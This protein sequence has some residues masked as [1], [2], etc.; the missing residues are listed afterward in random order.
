[1]LLQGAVA[2][3]DHEPEGLPAC[4]DGPVGVFRHPEYPGP[5]GQHPSQPG[6]VVEH[7]G[8]SLGLAQEGEAPPIL[9]H[10]G[11]LTSQGKAELKG[12][13]PRVAG[14]GQVREGLEALLEG[15]H[16]LA[17][18]GA[19]VGPSASLLAISDGL[20]PHLAPQGVVRQAFDRLGR[21]LRHERFEGL[22]QA[23][24]QHPPPLQ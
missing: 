4:G 3:L 23:R 2:E 21:P 24:M 19:I 16:R 11:Q 17:E 7:P 9:S 12:Q 6:P 15:G 14:L 22:D 10:S 5:L 13:P 20:A 8:Q 1:M 18:R